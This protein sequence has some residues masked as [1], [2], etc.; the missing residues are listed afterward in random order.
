MSDYYQTLDGPHFDY[1]M[2]PVPGIGVHTFRGP[3]PDLSRPYFAVFGGAQAMG[4]FVHRPFAHSLSEALELPCLNLAIGGAG[5][6]FALRPEV[7]PLLQRARFVVVQAPSGRSA[8]CSLFDNTTT[9]RNSG[10]C[11]RTG[12]H[13]KA[14]TFLD[15]LFRRRDR[16][17]LERFVTETRADYTR[18]MQLLGRALAGR[19]VLLWMSVREPDYRIDWSRPEGVLGPY[20]QLVCG[21]TFD[22]CAAAF[23]H[24]V[25]SACDEGLPQ[26]LW[27]AD[28]AVPAT[29][30]D[31]HGRLWNRYY[32]SPE[33]HARA[34]DRLLPV[35]R[36]LLRAGT[37]ATSR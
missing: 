37:D 7:L 20:P 29:R 34:A 36:E 17:L 2:R 16:T 3:I 30:R 15:E 24:R 35:C 33:M 23:A 21:A 32:P 5:P 6:R 25:D 12:R 22:A 11:V 1:G 8:T 26:P 27:I 14:E 9:G 18:S 28:A 13:L 10:R 31:A 19:G 4:R